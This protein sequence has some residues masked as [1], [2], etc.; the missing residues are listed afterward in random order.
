MKKELKCFDYDVERE[1]TEINL[2]INTIGCPFYPSL[3]DSEI[4]MEKT[5]N[6]LIEVGTVTTIVFQA[7]RN[8]IYPY[9]QVRL[10]NEIAKA[11]VYFVKERKILDKKA[12]GL[13]SCPSVYSEALDII[14]R[15]ILEQ[16]KRDPIGAYVSA[17]RTLREKKAQLDIR[18]EE[19]KCLEK[20]IKVLEEIVDYL[21]KTQLIKLAKPYLAG[22]K[23]GTR[24]LYFKFFEPLIR[25]NFMFTRLQAEPPTM[26]EEIESYEIGKELKSSVSIL[27][28]PNKVRL[29]YHILPPEFQLTEDEYVLLDEARQV[30]ARYKPKEEE[31]IDPERMRSVF[32]NIAKDLIAQIA[33]DKKIDISY[34]K[35]EKL[36]KILVRLTVGFGLIE[37]L[38]EDPKVEDIYINAPIGRVPIFIKHSDY[39][40]CETNII[41]QRREA[42]AWASRFRMISGRPLDEANPV[43]DTELIVPGVA[44]ARTAIIQNPLSPGGYAFAFRQHRERPWTL[45][46]FMY[47]KTISKEGA[48]LLSFLVDGAR[49]MLIAGTRGAGKT[50]LLGA[51]MVEIM[52]KFRIITVEDTLELPVRYLKNIGYNILSMKVRS[53]IVG[54]KAELSAE[55]GIRTSLRLGDSALIVGEVRSTEAKALYEAMRV[56]ALANVVAGTIHG[57]SPYGVFDRVVNDIGVPRTSFKATDI[58]VIAGKLRT[59]DQLREIRRTTYI[60]EVRKTWEEDPLQEG[61]FLNLM[62]YDAKKD[63][64]LPTRDLV[65]GETEVIKSIASKVRD[66]VGRWDLVWENIVLR[67][68]IK[69]MLVDYAEKTGRITGP[70]GLLEA[71]FVVEANDM[72]HRIFDKLREETGYPESK[73]VKR[74]FENWLKNRIKKGERYE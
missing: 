27:K 6:I 62:E 35:I 63:K 60:T 14:R 38:L 5:I 4:C 21:G 70:R 20:F 30:I 44:R 68:D 65:E 7:E 57:D 17:V 24:D 3:E 8:Y 22:Y 29:R 72:F 34:R 32:F 49:S 10:L 51:I 66:W 28:L 26:A 69:Q 43:L 19:K 23:V 67:S 50:S 71:D 37:V 18:K 45:P 39:G 59:P 9:Q 36:S 33:R 46:L 11:Y 13:E 61:G 56:G 40:E 54:E 16:L 2:I 52:R 55:D 12:L 25:P 64:L 73:D 41:P 48:G 58:I 42:E 1:G 53:A 15:I 31:F 74:E 47:N